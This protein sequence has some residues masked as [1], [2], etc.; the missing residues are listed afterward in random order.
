MRLGAIEV[1]GI[2]IILCITLQVL[3]LSKFFILES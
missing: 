1:F 3:D 2:C